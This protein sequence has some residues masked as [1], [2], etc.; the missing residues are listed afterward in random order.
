MILYLQIRNVKTIM[1]VMIEV[2]TVG[3]KS[4]ARLAG[5][6]RQ[7]QMGY[8]GVL[9]GTLGS[10]RES[11]SKCWG[12]TCGM[13]LRVRCVVG[14]STKPKNT[15]HPRN[16]CQSSVKCTYQPR[17]A[18]RPSRALNRPLLQASDGITRSF[19]LSW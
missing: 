9:G 6:I 10:F 15:A 4:P 16:A 3:M 13:Y 19:S 11:H 2:S 8:N 5:T 7:T 18:I 17:R 1:L 12:R 14:L